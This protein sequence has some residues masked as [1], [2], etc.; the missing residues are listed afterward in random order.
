MLAGPIA[1]HNAGMMMRGIRTMPQPS[2]AIDRPFRARF[3]GVLTLPVVMAGVAALC[4]LAAILLSLLTTIQTHFGLKPTAHNEI[5]AFALVC[6]L[7]ALW[8]LMAPVFAYLNVGQVKKVE[9]IRGFYTAELIADYFDQFWSGRDSIADLVAQ[10]RNSNASQR[11]ALG[12]TLSERFRDIIAKDFG[13]S[14]YMVPTVLL[15]AIGFLVLFF[16]FSGGI[17]YAES[18]LLQP[19]A[20]PPVMPLGLKLDLVSIA[21]IFGAYTWV[22]SDSITRGHQWTFH[23]S[24]LSWYA[25]RL[26]IAVP[27]GQAIA[28]A[29]QATTQSA[30]SGAAAPGVGAFLAFVVSMFSLDGIKKFLSA[31]ATRMGNTTSTTPSERDDIVV[32]L[33]GVDE[34]AAA[35]LKAEAVGT[36][37]QL[38]AIDP[39]RI[40]IL[41]GLPFEYVLGLVDS[42][43]L[44]TFFRDKTDQLREFGLRGA[45]GLVAYDDRANEHD[46]AQA[47]GTFADAEAASRAA[48]KR[49]DSAAAERDAARNA[50]GPDP[51]TL[52]QAR[53]AL[54]AIMQEPD[55]EAARERKET[56][57]AKIAALERLQRCED[58][59]TAAKATSDAALVAVHNTAAAL[60]NV[61]TKEQL[62]C[63]IEKKVGI[64]ALGLSQ[65]V[66]QLRT[67]SYAQFI[68]QLLGV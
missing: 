21:A 39:V 18:L 23:S 61:A 41:T 45:S 44:W 28:A 38:T 27:L 57:Q 7:L 59:F 40:S 55:Q 54:A 42:A 60:R 51:I 49:T 35:A 47:A 9:V 6:D 22:A 13:S 34:E 32:K 56:M 19:P 12:K 8:L 10:W 52:E 20:T 33:A 62:F 58:G 50:V 15:A 68:R 53:Q 1:T 25:L 63:A 36:I 30:A 2:V 64:N 67:D 65:A 14:V 29:T 4:V 66:A 37:A 31:A 3:G 43:I 16:G 46:L 11:D 26:L 17:A 5:Y 48:Q 24:D